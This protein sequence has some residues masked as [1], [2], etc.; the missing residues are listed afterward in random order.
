MS[1]S[2]RPES[3]WRASAQSHCGT[4]VAGEAGAEGEDGREDGRQREGRRDEDAAHDDEPGGE[5]GAEDRGGERRRREER[6]PGDLEFQAASLGAE[7][8][9]G[10][11]AGQKRQVE[12]APERGSGGGE[13]AG[14]ADGDAGRPPGGVEVE[15]SGDAGAVEAAQ[16]GGDVRQEGGG[17][18]VAGEDADET[19]DQGE[20]DEFGDENGRQETGGDADGAQGAQHRFALFEGEADGG[21][22]DE[23]ADDEAEEPEGGEVEVE[24]VGQAFEIAVAFG[25]ADLEARGE[26]RGQVAGFGQE[27]ARDPAGRVE[28][29]FGDGDVDEDGAGGQVR[30]G[31]ERGEAVVEPGAGGREREM[32]R[33]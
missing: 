2:E 28:Q 8:G 15:A 22:D 31:F 17:D 12:G 25:A 20:R 23:E 30:C 3:C 32:G 18:R 1:A 7:P 10:L 4:G 26:V 6:R 33:G 24:A 27:Q 9:L 29:A 19:G 14:D 11:G 13:R 16:G 5:A 21:I